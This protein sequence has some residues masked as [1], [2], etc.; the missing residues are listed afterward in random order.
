LRIKDIFPEKKKIIIILN[1]N[2]L[3]NNIEKA[4][5]IHPNETKGLK[6]SPIT[7]HDL[8]NPK[9]LFF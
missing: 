9:K 4:I 5:A 1:Y 2:H 7:E 8:K 6:R 3:T